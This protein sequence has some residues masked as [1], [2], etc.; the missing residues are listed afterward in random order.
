MN[1]IKQILEGDDIEHL[2][3]G[4]ISKIYKTGLIDLSDSETLSLIKIYHPQ[5]FASRESELLRF[6][7]LSYKDLSEP[8]TLK[9]QIFKMYQE[10]I[11]EHYNY[12]YT[13]VQVDIAS[14]INQNRVFS[15]S[16]PTST[17]KSYLIMNLIRD[18]DTDVVVVVP[19]RALINE[20]FSKLCSLIPDKNVN[21]LTFVEKVNTA[22]ANKNVFIVTPERCREIFKYANDFNIGL[23][24]FDEAQLSNEENLRGMYFDNI[25][26]RC[27][28]KFNNAKLVFAQPF[29]D[30]PA[31]QI[32]RNNLENE[33][34]D[35]RRY[36]QRNVGQFYLAYDG[37]EFFHFGIYKEIMGSQKIKCDFNPILKSIEE[38]GSV[39]FY[40]SKSKIL[41]RDF[42]QEFEPYIKLCKKITDERALELISK[43]QQYTGGKTDYSRNYYSLFIDLLSRGIVVHHGSMPLEARLVVED[44]T[45]SGFCRI[46]FATSTLEQG[47]NMPFDIVFLDRL[48]ASDPIGVKN[49]IGRAGRSTEAPVFDY[50]CVIIRSSGMTKFR[51]LMSTED[52]LS[53]KSMLDEE[54]LE[55]DDLEEIKQELNDGSYDDNLNLPQSKLQRLSDIESDQ[56]ISQL[57]DYL[58]YKNKFISS[59][60]VISNGE[61]WR[62]MIDLFVKFYAHYIRRELSKGEI[63]ILH[64]AIRILV[65]RVG[66]KTFKNMC[67]LRYQYVSRAK[68]RAE[69]NRNKWEFK[70]P[71]RFTAKYQEIPNKNCFPVSLFDLGTAATSVD[72]DSIIYDTYD[73]L[74]KLIGFKLSDILYAAFLKFYERHHEDR[75]LAAANYIKYGTND[76][77]EIWLLKYGVMF[78]DMEILKPHIQEINEQEIVVAQSYYNLPLDSRKIIERFVN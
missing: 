67:Q 44:F 50:G 29:V 32:E 72:Y 49:L 43:I 16:A 39:L 1:R 52:H 34:G 36:K 17:G 61:R 60:V 46:C 64:T 71:A 12:T 62:N 78:E 20:Y 18:C 65:W 23:F 37:S 24:L 13:P 48:E 70:K 41:S 5:V 28:N 15:F 26:R 54:V 56:L 45:K 9:E 8:R 40:V 21:I 33:P 10:V 31:S 27:H 75:A 58:F 68:E 30:N 7:A 19:S 4:V 2:L 57:L 25:V 38:G 59:D 47:I 14:G 77:K 42:Y 22:H 6:M 66:A 53:S 51:K 76:S 35:S 73:Y 63:S 69:Y 55:D 11:Y 3:D 74:D